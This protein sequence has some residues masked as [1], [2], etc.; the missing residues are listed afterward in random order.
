MSKEPEKGT[1][2]QVTGESDPIAEDHGPHMDELI[3]AI[4]R[5]LLRIALYVRVFAI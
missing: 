1:S 4:R 3:K 5:I 2:L